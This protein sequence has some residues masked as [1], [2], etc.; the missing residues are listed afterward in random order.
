MSGQRASEPIRGRTT[1][2]RR[3]AEKVAADWAARRALAEAQE[4]EIDL[5]R[6]SAEAEVELARER[7]TR[8]A[9]REARDREREARDRERVARD[10][11]RAGRRQPDLSGLPP[12]LAASGAFGALT[13]RLGPAGDEPRTRGRHASVTAVPH[14]AKSYLAAALVVGAGERILWIARD[15]EI[16]DRVAEELAGWLGDPGAVAVLEPR[17]ALAYERSELVPDETAARVAALSAWRSGSARV[18]V[19]SVQALLQHTISP[20]DLPAEPRRIRTGVRLSLD[21]LP[22]RPPVARLPAGARGRRSRRVR[23]TRRHRRPVPALGGAPRP[24]R[25]VRR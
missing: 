11:P 14:G 12:L 18:L 2:E 13:E 24:G 21:V 23:P 9:E 1:R 7:Q 22:A 25:D 5:D 4:A 15:A 10:V 20:D 3:L 8:D 16:G 19:A 6:A 17:T